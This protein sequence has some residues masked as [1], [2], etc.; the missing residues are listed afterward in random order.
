[1]A[2]EK[3]VTDEQKPVT[4]PAPDAVEA[5]VTPAEAPA[6]EQPAPDPVDDDESADFDLLG[7]TDEEVEEANE[8][9]NGEPVEPEEVTATPPQPVAPPEETVVA[10]NSPAPVSE[11]VAPVSEDDLEKIDPEAAAEDIE[12]VGKIAEEAQKEVAKRLGEEFDQFDPR[13]IALFQNVTSRLTREVVA[14]VA[15]QKQ[16]RIAERERKRLLPNVAAH[17]FAVEKFQNLPYKEAMK[18]RQAEANGDFKT[19]TDFFQRCREEF[20]GQTAVK[21]KVAD[22]IAAIK[23]GKPAP[24]PTAEALT[25]TVPEDDDDGLSIFGM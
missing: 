23:A 4:P 25:D 10:G 14:E 3:T 20:D 9:A 21:G 17:Q 8:E 1:M 11:P 18:I 2:I 5:P 22:K 19:V 15:Y 13:H 16:S 6:V 12:V 7:L 24:K